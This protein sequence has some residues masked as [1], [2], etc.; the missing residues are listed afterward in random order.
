MLGGMGNQLASVIL[1]FNVLVLLAHFK[2]CFYEGTWRNHPLHSPYY[3]ES[4][5]LSEHTLYQRSKI[6]DLGSFMYYTSICP[7]LN[8]DFGRM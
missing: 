2:H 8:C 4:T 1:T 3:P 5:I 6:I 7:S